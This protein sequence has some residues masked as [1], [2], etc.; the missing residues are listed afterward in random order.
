M[1][2]VYQNE[3]VALTRVVEPVERLLYRLMRADVRR[4]QDW[5]SYARTA[6]VRS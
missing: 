4:E 2:R 1:A 3:M 6:I 5:K